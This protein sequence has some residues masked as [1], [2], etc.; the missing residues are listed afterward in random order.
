MPVK[1]SMGNYVNIH[2]DEVL[3]EISIRYNE[4]VQST[5]NTH[6]HNER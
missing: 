3:G 2:I 5:I 1:I 4:T 6:L